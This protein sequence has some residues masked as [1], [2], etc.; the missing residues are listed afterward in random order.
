M[1]LGTSQRSIVIVN[2]AKQEVRRGPWTLSP[3]RA[4]LMQMALRALSLSSIDYLFNPCCGLYHIRTSHR[5][6]CR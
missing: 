3:S 5:D 1:F 2:L 6:N 4:L